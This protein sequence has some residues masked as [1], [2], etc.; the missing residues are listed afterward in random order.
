MIKRLI[1]SFLTIIAITFI[2]IALAGSIT[3]PQVQSRLELYQIDLVLNAAQ[4]QNSNPTINSDIALAEKA[5]F[6]DD[7]YQSAIDQYQQVR[8]LA[9][10][11]LTQLKTNQ[12]DKNPQSLS[13]I[14]EQQQLIDELNV[15]L[16]ILQIEEGNREEAFQA[17]QTVIN[18]PETRFPQ[19]VTTAEVLTSLWQPSQELSPQTEFTLQQNLKGWFRDRALTQLY[20]L[21]NRATD[22]ATLTAQA[23]I[24]AQQAVIKLS[25]IN[26]IP[27]FG[28][29][30]GIGLIIF[31]V[32]QGLLKRQDSLLAKNAGLGWETPW[33][34][35]IILQVFVVGFILVGQLLVPLTL[36][37]IKQITHLGN[38]LVGVRG[39]AAFILATY[40]TFGSTTLMIAYYSL[41]SFFPLPSGWFNCNW[42]QNWLGWGA[43]GYCVALPLVILVSL[44]NQ[45]IW[46]GQGGSNPILSIALESQD[47]VALGIFFITASLA[48]PIFEELMFRGFLLPS[49]TRYVPLWGAIGI[50]SL[51]FAVA[52]QNASEILP[53]FVL[54]CV[55]G[56]VYTRSRNLLS[57]MLL[58]SL[59]NSGTLLS[60][61]ILG[62]GAG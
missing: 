28:L 36:S 23:Q 26:A 48:A 58:H 47:W 11:S 30:V 62:G 24:A 53:L 55:L 10:T 20:E 1:L 21:Q 49:L 41:K 56:F 17:W 13:L 43:G 4:W 32:I 39:D 27:G 33:D 59:W 50:S 46:Q 15:R 29:I 52:H 9:Q 3:E 6:G 54:G 61:Y 60:L 57:S 38:I 25:V 37:L 34:G 8:Q 12:T 22:L 19:L 2:G 42:R 44:M 51:L 7:V 40:L 35:E 5:L 31:L 18:N 45:K 16:G 14:R